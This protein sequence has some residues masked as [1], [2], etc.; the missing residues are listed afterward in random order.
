M[1]PCSSRS[2]GRREGGIDPLRDGS[3]TGRWHVR[4][5]NVST[6]YAASRLH[7]EAGFEDGQIAKGQRERLGR[8]ETWTVQLRTIPMPPGGP[9]AEESGRN[10][11]LRYSDE[12]GI[13][14]YQIEFGFV[15]ARRPD[16]SIRTSVSMFP[17][18]EAIRI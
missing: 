4:I 15:S 5:L 1:W 10:A 7:F 13:L 14:R 2:A 18:S 12:R 6:Q 3:D 16:G 17:V 9:S 11:F 8:G